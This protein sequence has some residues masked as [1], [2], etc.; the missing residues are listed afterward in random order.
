MCRSLVDGGRRCPCSGGAARR[1]YQRARYAHQLAMAAAAPAAATAAAPPSPADPLDDVSAFYDAAEAAAAAVEA[2]LAAADLADPTVAAPVWRDPEPTRRIAEDALRALR[3]EL[4]SQTRTPE[5]TAAY[6][7]AVTAHGAVLRDNALAAT[8]AA[9]EEAGVADHQLADL[10][11]ADDAETAAMLDRWRAEIADPATPAAAKEVAKLFLESHE[12]RH[13]LSEQAQDALVEANTRRVE[14]LTRQVRETL[15]GERELGGQ[16]RLAPQAKLKKA[17]RETLDDAVDAFPAGMIDFANGRERP[18]L[19]KATTTRAHYRGRAPLTETVSLTGVIWSENPDRI[20]YALRDVDSVE[21][22]RESPNFWKWRA[23][24]DT[25]ENRAKL[26]AALERYRIMN[27][28]ADRARDRAELMEVTVENPDGTT[29]KRVY[30]GIEKYT[31][32]K[33]TRRGERV[34]ELTFSDAASAV[35]EFAHHI[36]AENAEVGEA[37]KRFLHRRTEGLEAETYI[38]ATRTRAEERVTA[39]GFVDR[40]MGRDYPDAHHTEIFSTGCEAILRGEFGGLLG[41]EVEISR[42]GAAEGRRQYRADPEHFALVLGLLA[43]ANKD[44]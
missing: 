11:D 38:P 9:W 8:E 19:P 1:A 27:R 25:L 22:D 21:V 33:V 15:T 20:D 3:V 24:E 40:Y 16:P 34:S 5:T 28:G 44:I 4:A 14:L 10:L 23:A 13:P 41:V 32:K 26:Q 35:H 31:R 42:R 12:H 30:I 29:E 37:C 43:T 7:A 6:I 18:L 36:E 39:D 2:A 17:D